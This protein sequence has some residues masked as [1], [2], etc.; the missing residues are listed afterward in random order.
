MVLRRWIQEDIPGS[1]A[2]S[3]RALLHPVEATPVVNF[4]GALYDLRSVVAHSGPSANAGHYVAVA[5]HDTPTGR[6]WMYND[7]MRRVATDDEVSTLAQNPRARVSA[8][9]VATWQS[10][11]LCYSR[12]RNA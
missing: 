1:D 11:I 4:G 10:Y 6:W 12:Q 5:R 2:R 3:V 8:D 9:P 7:S